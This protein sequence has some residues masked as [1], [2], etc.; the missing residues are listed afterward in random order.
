[1][2]G[3]YTTK[4]IF[5]CHFPFFGVNFN[6]FLGHVVSR[7]CISLI[8]S[9]SESVNTRRVSVGIFGGLIVEC[10]IRGDGDFKVRPNCCYARR[11]SNSGFFFWRNALR[12][13]CIIVKLYVYELVRVLHICRGCS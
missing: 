7:I 1:M 13:V 4:T 6:V 11:N 9:E 3:R 8:W 10:G 5:S 12:G 2:D